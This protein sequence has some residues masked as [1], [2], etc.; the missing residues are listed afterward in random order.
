MVN[1][2]C[3]LAPAA[4]QSYLRLLVNV[5]SPHRNAKITPKSNLNTSNLGWY[6][7]LHLDRSWHQ[8]SHCQ[9]PL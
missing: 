2:G 1:N 9:T 4:L 6:I 8:Q 7:G 3:H 5:Y